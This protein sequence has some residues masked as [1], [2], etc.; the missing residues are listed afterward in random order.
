VAATRR[1]LSSATFRDAYGLVLLSRPG[2]E[3]SHLA[4][5]LLHE[6][7]HLKLSA[8]MDLFPLLR[9]GA[10][11][12]Y[13]APWRRQWRPGLNVLQGGFAHLAVGRFW[14]EQARREP[15]GP[16]RRRAEQ[17]GRYWLRATEQSVTALHTSGE[18]T[19]FGQRFAGWMLEACAGAA[20]PRP[21]VSRRS[22]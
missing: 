16:A 8:L 19:E 7:Q 12:L 13:W 4:A 21:A 10:D 17:L 6:T 22:P 11:R 1:Q 20:R 15:P 14:Q 9:P 3:P 5:A 2:G 18:L